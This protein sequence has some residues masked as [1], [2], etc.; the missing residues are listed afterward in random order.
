MAPIKITEEQ[1]KKLIQIS[2]EQ[3]KNAHCPYSK[4]HVGAALLT[5][6]GE[7]FRGS[8]VENASYGLTICAERSAI[9]SAVSNGHKKFLGIAISTDLKE[10]FGSPC[11]ACRQVL[12]EFGL[13]WPVYLVNPHKGT[14]EESTVGYFLPK[15]FAPDTLGEVL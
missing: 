10:S 9:V 3:R 1:K 7:I 4:F 12:A 14:H 13:D 15:A 6:S 11:G 2:G 8:N 5:E